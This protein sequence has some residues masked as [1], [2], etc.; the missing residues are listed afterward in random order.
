MKTIG[1][2]YEMYNASVAK[3]KMARNAVVDPML[4]NNST[5]MRIERR[6][7]ALSGIFNVG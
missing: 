2:R 7:S 3:D 6:A 1:I 5:H 4:I